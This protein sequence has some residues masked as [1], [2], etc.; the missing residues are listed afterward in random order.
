MDY[1]FSAF[2]EIVYFFSDWKKGNLDSL[3]DSLFRVRLYMTDDI[4]VKASA[5]PFTGSDADYQELPD[6][7][8][9]DHQRVEDN[10]RIDSVREVGEN[11]IHFCGIRAC[12]FDT[13]LG[14]SKFGRADHFHRAGDLSDPA[15]RL[16]ALS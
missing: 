10:F 13:L 11:L 14:A 8:S 6:V 2:E 15:D 1:P 7:L 16:N 12:G 9:R 3:F 5:Q 4:R